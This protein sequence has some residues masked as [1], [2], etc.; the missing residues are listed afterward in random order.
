MGSTLQSEQ[1]ATV[2]RNESGTRQSS[3]EV[4]LCTLVYTKPFEFGCRC[5]LG[6]TCLW[7]ALHLNEVS[8]DNHDIDLNRTRHVSSLLPSAFSIAGQYY[9]AHH[10]AKRL[11]SHFLS[12]LTSMSRFRRGLYFNDEWRSWNSI[13]MPSAEQVPRFHR[14]L[15]DYEPTPLRELEDLAKEVGVRAIYLK[16]E[17]NRFGLPSF[18]ILGA[19]WG[20]FRA[21][22]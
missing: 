13:P 6:N 21:I 11:S 16:D 5:R 17:G 12:H 4:P 8:L 10:T 2:H 20:T 9:I 22:A 15:P 3:T 7:R 1:Y 18:K 14:N 19:S